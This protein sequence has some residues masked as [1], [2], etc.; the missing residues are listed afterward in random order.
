MALAAA[1]SALFA[2]GCGDGSTD[3]GSPPATLVS[4]SMPVDTVATGERTDPPIA[5]RVEDALGNPVEGAAVRFLI[6]RG[7][8][9][10]S[11]GVAVAGEEGL[12]ESFYRAGATP[13]EAEIQVDI[14]S[15]T[16]V[17]PLR[18]IVWA[19][20]ADTVTLDLVEGDGQQAEA[21]SQLPLPFLLRAEALSGVP[22]GGVQVA[23][24]TVPPAAGDEDPGVLEEIA[25]PGADVA[26][27][28]LAEPAAAPDTTGPPEGA[29]PPLPEPDT[30]PGHAAGMLTHDL[31]V[32]D[33]DGLGQ[34]V[35]TLGREPGEYRV[36]VFATGGVYSDTVAF[37]ATA[38][39]ALDGA[40][41][42]DSVGGGRLAAGTRAV[43]LGSGFSPVPA[44]NQ[45]RIEGEPAPVV[46]STA[47]TLTIEVPAFPGTCRPQREVGVRVLVRSEPSNGLLLPIAPAAR[48][49]EL[50]VGASLT[51]RGPMEVECVH[52]PPGEEARDFRV[53]IGNTGRDAT[54]RLPLRVT[55]R[56]PANLSG[57]GPATPVT[58]PPLDGDL[59][60]LA[61]DAMRIDGGIRVRTLARLVEDGIAPFRPADPPPG[62]AAPAMGDTLDYVFAVGPERVANCAD[63]TRPLRGAVRAVGERVLLVEDL[64]APEGGPAPEEWAALAERLDR[65]VVPVTTSYFGP[66]GD[67][68]RNGRVIV[69]FTPQLNGIGDGTGARGFFLPLDL[70]A[71]GREGEGRPEPAGPTCPASNEAEIIYSVSAD[72]EGSAGPPIATDR[73]LRDVPALVAHELQ[74]LI[75]AGLRVS[76]AASG[77]AAS[78]EAWLDEALSAAAEEI[79]GLAELGLPAGE[80]LTF[81]QV[82][83]SPE[84]LEIFDAYLRRNFLNLGLYLM[85]TAETPTI[86]GEGPGGVAGLQMRGFGWFLLRWLADREGADE[87]SFF[88]SLASGGQNF[89]RGIANLERVTGREW[90]DIL[91]EFS[92]ALALD[93]ADETEGSGERAGGPGEAGG[94]EADAP[95]D[96]AGRA[97]PATWNTP[98][99]FASLDRDADAPTFSRARFPLRAE[100]LR[101][102]TRVM[103]IDVGASSVQ[104]FSLASEAGAPALSLS[105]RT[106]AGA[107]ADETAE[108]LITIVRTR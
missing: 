31:V 24:R 54:R 79:A 7:E 14:P 2:A 55:T 87:R 39:E 56:T 66:P 36:E 103:E 5:V 57:E 107:P 74:H 40:V 90:A 77:F 50:E 64:D 93:A 73:L 28:P 37:T 72:P 9:E 41:R 82:S 3:V 69:L 21:G 81:A 67:I 43:L 29:E 45:V 35:Y 19:V 38:L 80:R 83:D 99:V 97:G 96:G 15:A 62:I 32:T 23:F 61:L 47:T 101:F 20:T 49:V 108:P 26:D 25:E 16:S 71:S 104:Y 12:A 92:V 33:G 65:A 102:E 51:L 48:R 76:H 98:D 84:R 22:A 70:A 63:L 30:L 100:P 46:S 58:P 4:V 6:V 105:V 10:V 85:G 11:P 75:N 52:F 94:A 91:A 1:A 27:D 18:F 34:A 13:G 59:E 95:M 89:A 53:I 60:G 42:L 78:E 106:E 88:R 86:T 17:T 68:D 8:G 44:D